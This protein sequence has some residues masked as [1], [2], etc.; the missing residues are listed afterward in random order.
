MRSKIVWKGREPVA[1]GADHNHEIGGLA[2][3]PSVPVSPE[4][5][6]VDEAERHAV[7]EQEYL[8]SPPRG[9]LR[10]ATPP[11]AVRPDRPPG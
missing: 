4:S 2:P 5:G 8:E 7:L 10:G 6:F 1:L 9:W 3:V 11:A